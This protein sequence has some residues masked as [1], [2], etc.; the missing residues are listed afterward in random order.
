MYIETDENPADDASRGLYAQDLINSLHWW[1][2]PEFLQQAWQ[3]PSS[4]NGAEPKQLSPDDPE[5]KGISTMTTQV[6]R[7]FFLSERLMSFSCSH[8]AKRAVAISLR[9]QKRYRT[10][11]KGQALSKSEEFHGGASKTM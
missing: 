1:S 2:G 6:Q 5:V 10:G 4:S 9:L 11:V 3:K 8:K 7:H